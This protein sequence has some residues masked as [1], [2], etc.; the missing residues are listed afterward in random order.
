MMPEVIHIVN[1]WRTDFGILRREQDFE[2]LDSDQ[3]EVTADYQGG[4]GLTLIG[5]L[6]LLSGKSSE[7]PG[8]G[9]GARF[10]RGGGKSFPGLKRFCGADPCRRGPFWNMDV[11]GRRPLGSSRRPAGGLPLKRDTVCS[12]KRLPGPPA[13]LLQ[14]GALAPP[15]NSVWI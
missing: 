14:A 4:L 12:A 10:V 9:K 1:W 3:R 6:S 13:H 15:Q 5:P 8:A 11:K 7:R 2:L